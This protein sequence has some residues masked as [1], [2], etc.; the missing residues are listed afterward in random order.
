MLDLSMVCC[1]SSSKHITGV[2]TIG[3]MASGVAWL[4]N[5]LDQL[6]GMVNLSQASH[7]QIKVADLI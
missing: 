4:E 6:G 7:L 1:V 5:R 2:N 3:W